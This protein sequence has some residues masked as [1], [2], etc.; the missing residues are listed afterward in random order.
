MMLHKILAGISAACCF[1]A[2]AGVAGAADLDMLTLQSLWSAGVLL[3]AGIITGAGAYAESGQKGRNREKN[4]M[5]Q[6]P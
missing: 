1:I 5:R 4:N 2:F 3:M 6:M